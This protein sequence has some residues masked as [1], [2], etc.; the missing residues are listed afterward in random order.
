M[1]HIYPNCDAARLF[2][3]SRVR[4]PFRKPQSLKTGIGFSARIRDSEAKEK[5]DCLA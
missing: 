5:R 1:A 2:F 3:F 4:S